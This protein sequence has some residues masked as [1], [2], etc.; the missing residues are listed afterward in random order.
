MSFI[1]RQT[2]TTS[3][4]VL[5]FTLGFIGPICS[6]DAGEVEVRKYSPIEHWT[7]TLSD[8]YGNYLGQLDILVFTQGTNET[9]FFTVR[10]FDGEVIG[11]FSISYSLNDADDAIKKWND[12]RAK[13]LEI[14][15]EYAMN[16]FARYIKEMEEIKDQV[17]LS[18]PG[19]SEPV[20]SID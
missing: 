11:S 2:V 5:C 12:A 14:A 3:L 1:N 8:K 7:E 19:K 13:A 10:G 4:A 16:N 15:M 9:A 17:I 18:D 6:V 20:E